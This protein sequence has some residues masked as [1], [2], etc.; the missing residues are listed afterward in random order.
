MMLNE[1]R[2]HLRVARIYDELVVLS[3]VALRDQASQWQ[4]VISG[5]SKAYGE[6]LHAVMPGFRHGCHNCRRVDA[7]TEEGAQGHVG[8]QPQS[9]CIF[10]Q[11][12]ELIDGLALSD[13]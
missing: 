5:V 3:T 12:I 11:C 13:C 6:C 1:P 10:E 7:A 8:N 2:Q 4:L 9:H